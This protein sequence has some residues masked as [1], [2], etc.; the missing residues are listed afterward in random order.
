MITLGPSLR[1]ALEQH[2]LAAYP[3]EACGLILNGDYVPCKNVAGDPGKTFKI[4]PVQLSLTPSFDA[5]FHSHPNGPD[6]PSASDMQSQIVTG[7]PWV[8]IS[9]DGK[10]C[11]EPFSFAANGTPPALSGRPFRHGVTDCYGLIR[12]WYFLNRGVVLPEYPRDWEWW[13]ENQNLY[14]EGFADAGF[15]VL[16]DGQQDLQPGDVFLAQTP[17]SPVINH[18]GIYLGQGLGLHHLSSD[19]AY[20]PTRLST[21]EPLVRW[22]PLIVKWLRYAGS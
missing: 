9:T 22:R 1:L 15:V 3:N 7:V 18:G 2:A 13:L 19:N 6:C 16:N 4:D 11:E 8:I 5:I 21:E 14:S 10:R 17:K 12:D 20:D